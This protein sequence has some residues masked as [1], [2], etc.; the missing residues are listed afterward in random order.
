MGGVHREQWRLRAAGFTDKK[1]GPTATNRND[2][3]L[4]NEST[5][6]FCYR[7][8]LLQTIC[9]LHTLTLS[10]TETFTV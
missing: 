3:S 10:I 7:F 2:E 9:P 1:K 4:K 8:F 5:T 6:F